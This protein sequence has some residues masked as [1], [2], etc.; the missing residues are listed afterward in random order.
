MRG[1]LSLS[2]SRR[3]SKAAIG[4][5]VSGDRSWRR[6]FNRSSWC[7]AAESFLP[8]FL[9]FS[10]LFF[11]SKTQPPE[12]NNCRHMCGGHHYYYLSNDELVGQEDLHDAAI[13][14][15]AASISTSS[16]SWWYTNVCVCW[17]PVESRVYHHGFFFINRATHVI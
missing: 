15:A 13:A 3:R 8:L 7:Q 17:V 4:F 9:S 5:L 11:Y 12:Q 6:L 2:S 1:L 16:S 14:R 10:L